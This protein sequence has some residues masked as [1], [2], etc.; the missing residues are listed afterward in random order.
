MNCFAL[1][2]YEIKFGR[3]FYFSERRELDLQGFALS[4][5]HYFQ[6]IQIQEIHLCEI[7]RNIE[8][9]LKGKVCFE[10]DFREQNRS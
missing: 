1:K 4:S 9:R 6:E 5:F 3:K 7:E 2:K 8:V 10:A